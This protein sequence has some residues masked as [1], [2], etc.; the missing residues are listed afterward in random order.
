MSLSEPIPIKK[1]CIYLGRISKETFVR[2]AKKGNGNGKKLDAFKIGGQWFTTEKA[3]E[4]FKERPS[5]GDEE[6]RS[7]KGPVS[8]YENELNE[9]LDL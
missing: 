6:Q 5:D 2:Y 1:A 7:P 8:R 9:M 3:I 4:D